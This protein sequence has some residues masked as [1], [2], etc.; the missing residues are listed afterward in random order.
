MLTAATLC[1]MTTPVFALDRELEELNRVVFQSVD[2][3]G[4]GMLSRRE[5]DLYRQ[6]VMLSQDYD[7]DGNIT[8]EEHLPWDQG[9][10]ALAEER[11]LADEYWEARRRV[12]DAWDVNGDGVLNEAEQS[13][14][15]SKDFYIASDRSSMAINFDTFK[16][17]LRIIA[18][19][20]DAVNSETDVTLIN[21]FEV[22][23]DA[24]DEAI[25]MWARGRDFLQ[26]QPGY[27]STALHKSIAPDAKFALINVAIWESV[28]DFQ[29]ASAAMRSNDTLP[30]IEGVTFTPSLYTI[31]A[32]D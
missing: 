6:D 31:V 1:L 10:Q 17:G 25:A 28:E 5:V 7:G 27:V 18:E 8:L 20:N 22:P 19:M 30:Q 9:W 29:A 3:N 24:L 14:S 15:Q 2:R 12:F 23:Q 21:V 26:T 13:L 32:T 4:D 16:S 11:G